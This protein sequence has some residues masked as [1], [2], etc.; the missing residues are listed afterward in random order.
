MSSPINLP[1]KMIDMHTN[2]CDACKQRRGLAKMVLGFDMDPFKNL[3]EIIARDKLL[4]QLAAN[5]EKCL[6][7]TIEE[8]Q[9][10]E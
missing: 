3:D 1:A 5:C 4:D 8:L 6:R 9:K 7:K 2:G 10:D